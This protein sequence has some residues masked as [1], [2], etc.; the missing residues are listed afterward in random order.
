MTEVVTLLREGG[1]ANGEFCQTPTARDI[2]NVLSVCQAQGWIGVVVGQPGTGKTTAITAYAGE[3]WSG[4]K[5]CRMTRAAAKLQPGLVR[6]ASAIGAYVEPH[7]G[8]HDIHQELVVVASNMD[9]GLIILDEAQHMDDDLLEAVRDLYDETRVGIVLVGN[10]ELTS[11]WSDQSNRRRY[12]NFAQLRGRI[13]PQID[14]SHP[15]AEDVEEI[16]RHRGIE[17]AR[18]VEIVKKAAKLPGALQKV[19]N[20]FEVASELGDGRITYT[21]LKQAAPVV[22]LKNL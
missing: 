11:R 6:L 4:A 1:K 16:C 13:G 7:R 9:R 3:S 12:N 15:S 2:M 14:L 17:G 19:R 5:V 18:A 8:A 10:H 20:L 21:S 22:G